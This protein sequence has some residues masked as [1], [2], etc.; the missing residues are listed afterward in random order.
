[1]VYFIC[2]LKI[3]KSEDLIFIETILI[4]SWVSLCIFETNHLDFAKGR[5]KSSDWGDGLLIQRPCPEFLHKICDPQKFLYELFDPHK[6]E[7]IIWAT[8]LIIVLYDCFGAFMHFCKNCLV[9]IVAQN[10]RPP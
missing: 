4:L 2:N 6:T 10:P 7:K 1:M 8:V 9:S 3:R 5:F